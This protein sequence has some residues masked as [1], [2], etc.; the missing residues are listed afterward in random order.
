MYAIRSYYE[1]GSAAAELIAHNP[2]RMIDDI[3]GIGFERADRISTSR[4]A[5]PSK[6]SLAL[7]SISGGTKPGSNWKTPARERVIRASGS[8]VSYNFV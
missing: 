4:R 8:T 2:Y 7:T 6:C 5:I 1:Y 3:V